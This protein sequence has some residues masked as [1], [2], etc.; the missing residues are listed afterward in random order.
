MRFGRLSLGLCL[1]LVAFNPMDVFSMLRR[2][3]PISR[4]PGRLK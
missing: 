3:L 2:S 1:S 4:E